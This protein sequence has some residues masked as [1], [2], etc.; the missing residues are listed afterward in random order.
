M[1]EETAFT[2]R[3]SQLRA[4]SLLSDLS[5]Y[6]HWHPHYTFAPNSTRNDLIRWTVFM[7]DR[8]RISV[9]VKVHNDDKPHSVGWSI[10]SNIIFWIRENYEIKPVSGGVNIRHIVESQGFLGKIL[11]WFFRRTVRNDMALQDAALLKALERQALWAHSGGQRAK[12]SN[13]P[14]KKPGRIDGR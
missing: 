5:N 6:K 10:Q 11:A 12:R 2:V 1:A 14:A 7:L 9:W 3:I 13:R 4:W 8:R